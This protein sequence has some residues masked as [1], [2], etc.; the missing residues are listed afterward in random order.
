MSIGNGA[1]NEPWAELLHPYRSYGRFDI[2]GPNEAGRKLSSMKIF[3][4]FR[5]GRVQA[6]IGTR[7]ST[8]V[9]IATTFGRWT[10]YAITHEQANGTSA[11]I[12]VNGVLQEHAYH[13]HIAVGQD[14]YNLARPTSKWNQPIKGL[15]LCTYTFYSGLY[16]QGYLDEF[17]IWKTIRTQEEIVRHMHQ[18]L[19]NP[20]EEDDLLAYYTFDEENNTRDGIAP[21]SSRNGYHLKYGGCAP[22]SNDT[23]T[24]YKG[25][26]PLL[27]DFKNQKWFSITDIDANN[28]IPGDLVCQPSASDGSSPNFIDGVVYGGH[29]CY[30]IDEE[31]DFARQPSENWPVVKPSHAPIG[32]QSFEQ[33]VIPRK[34]Q[35]SIILNATDPDTDDQV[36]LMIIIT[37]MPDP[38][39]GKLGVRIDGKDVAPKI[40][41]RLPLNHKTVL[42]YPVHGVGGKKIANFS[43]AITDGVLHS[44]P[45]VVYVSI[46]CEVGQFVN[47]QNEC[48]SCPSGTYSDNQNLERAC[49]PCRHDEYQPNPGSRECNVCQVG[50]FVD[51]TATTCQPCSPNFKPKPGPFPI[52][53]NGCPVT[54]QYVVTQ[55]PSDIVLQMAD[56]ID[57][58]IDRGVK[59]GIQAMLTS[60]PAKGTIYQYS[61]QSTPLSTK[62]RDP[63]K[64]HRGNEEGISQ[65]ASE[66]LDEC[67][68]DVSDGRNDTLHGILGPPRLKSSG[69]RSRNYAWGVCER[70]NKFAYSYNSIVLK[71]KQAI[72]LTKIIVSESYLPGSLLRI[73][74]WQNSSS[75]WIKLWNAIPRSTGTEYSTTPITQ[76]CVGPEPVDRLRITTQILRTGAPSQLEAVLITGMA[77]KEQLLSVAFTD[78]EMRFIYSYNANSSDSLPTGK[79]VGTTDNFFDKFSVKLRRCTTGGI[80]ENQFTVILRLHGDTSVASP[81]TSRDSL[82]AFVFFIPMIMLMGIM[83]VH[84]RRQ[85]AK[86]KILHGKLEDARNTIPESALLKKHEVQLTRE[87]G[88]GACGIVHLAMYRGMTVA[89]KRLTSYGLHASAVMKDEI[90]VESRRMLELRHP[91]IGKVYIPASFK[92]ILYSHFYG[93]LFGCE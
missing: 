64:W 62:K 86:R 44:K 27:K 55:K 36:K 49:K 56:T 33:F 7:S 35:N 3:I 4:I 78:P 60:L 25:F 10:H 29:P 30:Y 84:L 85:G 70:T 31:G 68:Q 73:E 93:M 65:Y 5:I 59:V 22:C 14:R 43:Y 76:L 23:G 50:S 74:A 34:V 91:N 67:G 8:S 19:P 66:V 81:P 57:E 47:A 24:V 41:E 2:S 11:K 32:G 71:Y 37:R 52:R 12:Y 38:K 90:E 69:K 9:N 79:G 83:V 15:T 20:K 18:N 17:R 48:E 63:L 82:L 54:L 80:T 72:F 39:Y 53:E 51:P 6:L 1:S 40:N 21:D 92:V 58:Y 77:S 75:S 87:L 42:F 26:S 16:H 13:D 61:S 45:S 89:V 46:L 88:R 28:S